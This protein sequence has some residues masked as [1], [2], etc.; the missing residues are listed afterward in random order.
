MSIKG[1][2]VH[3]RALVMGAAAS[4]AAPGVGAQ[5]PGPLVGVLSPFS[6]AAAAEWHRAFEHGLQGLGWTPG[7][8][9]RIE[10]RYGDGDTAQLPRLMDELM[11]LKPDLLLTEVTEATQAARKA[12]TAVPIVMVAVGDPVAIG[13]VASLARPGGNVTGLSQNIVESAGKRLELLRAMGG[14]SDIAVLWNPDDENSML[15]WRALEAHA[16]P[17]GLPLKSLPAHTAA[18]IES[19]ITGPG[20]G[21]TRAVY[22]VPGPLFVTNL[23]RIAALARERR[24]ASIFHLPDYV[25][26]GGLLSYGPDRSDLFRR[27]AG[28]VDRI[29]KGAKPADLPVEQPNKFE[30][31][32]NLGTARAI[33]L[34]IPPLMLVQ[35]G[36]VVE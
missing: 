15:N 36:E 11:R 7:A 29:L 20:V 3:R 5:S 4:L 18:E 26:M 14:G 31:S 6:P 30:L 23:S 2:T 16:G 32:I 9:L 10:Y 17:L 1:A 12:T 25:H 33:G 19:A 28:Y 27:A 13:L 34:V 35:A 22:V 8:K 21:E 24:L